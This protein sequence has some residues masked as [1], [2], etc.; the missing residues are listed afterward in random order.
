MST[1]RRGPEYEKL[2]DEERIILDITEAMAEGMNARG[3][4]REEVASTAG[5]DP[6]R[7][8]TELAGEATMNLRD[9][10]RVARVL[11]LEPKLLSRRAAA[12]QRPR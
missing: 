9:L 10:I 5:V 2:L 3:M 8:R 6:E 7:L 12:R 4:N 1:S 11:D